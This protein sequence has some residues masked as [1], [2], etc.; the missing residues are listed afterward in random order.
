MN[1]IQHNPPEIRP[2]RAEDLGIIVKIDSL[3]T[4]KA[5]PEYL[6]QK[7]NEALD[8]S[9]GLITSMVAVIDG[10]VVGFIMGNVFMGEF[11]IPETTATIDTIGIDPEYGGRGV[12][13]VLLDD[14]LTHLSAAGVESVQTL[15]NWEDWNL[16]KFFSSNKFTP[17]KTINLERKIAR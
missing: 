2:I 8:A 7:L 4:G 9:Q 10:K 5:R 17:S 14:Y 3:H 15:V 1:P 12:A 11:G 16:L 13:K 6:K